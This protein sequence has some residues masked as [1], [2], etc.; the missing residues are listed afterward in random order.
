MLALCLLGAVATAAQEPTATP[1]PAA[2][3]ANPASAN[4]VSKGGKLII[5]RRGDGG[6]YGVCLFEDNRQCEEWALFRGECPVGGIKVTGY[7]TAANYGDTLPFTPFPSLLPLGACLGS[8]G[9][10]YPASPIM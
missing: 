3:V 8:H 1:K 9:S 10:S 4:C 5:D 2:A 7:V 6:D